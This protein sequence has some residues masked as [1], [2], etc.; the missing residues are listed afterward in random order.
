[1]PR[2]QNFSQATK[3]QTEIAQVSAP[4]EE[5]SIQ[6][7]FQFPLVNNP[8]V[9]QP[10]VDALN[11]WRTQH[12]EKIST[13]KET[14][15][16]LKAKEAEPINKVIA[17]LELHLNELYNTEEGENHSHGVQSNLLNEIK[18]NYK[19][20]ANFFVMPTDGTE[21]IATLRRMNKEGNQVKKGALIDFWVNSEGPDE[22]G[23]MCMRSAW[24][25]DGF[26]MKAEASNQI[27][28]D[29][30]LWRI[31]WY[32]VNGTQSPQNNE[33]SSNPFDNVPTQ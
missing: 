20:A 7:Q 10:Q 5:S 15:K 18:S 2:I 4:K 29:Y 1:M 9:Y 25:C 11:N 8:T 12:Q 27:E 33:N 24:K 6:G 26:H 14:V 16:G 3:D 28:A 22:N 32:K 21:P 17:S 31:E 19:W 13:L 30:Q 23:E